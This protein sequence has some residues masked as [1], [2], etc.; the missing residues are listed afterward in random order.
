ME[1]TVQQ[2][3]ECPRED[4]DLM[5]LRGCWRCPYYEGRA[6]PWDKELFEQLKAK[7][8]GNK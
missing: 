4:N 1:L 7:G 8:D 5:P 2:A 6:P 3:V